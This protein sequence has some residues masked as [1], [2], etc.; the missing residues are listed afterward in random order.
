MP[1]LYDEYIQKLINLYEDKVN[2]FREGL[3]MAGT[4]RPAKIR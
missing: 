4:A 3:I 1:E 2:Q